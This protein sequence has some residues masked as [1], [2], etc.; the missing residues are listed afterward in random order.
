ME[1]HKQLKT[2]IAVRNI[3]SNLFTEANC[4]RVQTYY[5]KMHKSAYKRYEKGFIQIKYY[6]N[7]KNM[8]KV[9]F[10]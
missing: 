7:L 6:S 5:Y 1:A 2:H 8:K 9:L 4:S 10:K 3:Q